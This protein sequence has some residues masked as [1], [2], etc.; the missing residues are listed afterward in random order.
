MR[1]SNCGTSE[2]G[3]EEQTG[4]MPA[5]SGSEASLALRELR[6]LARLVQSGLLAL[7]LT[8]VARKEAFPLEWHAQLGIDLDERPCDAVAYCAGLAA[9]ATAVDA[10][11]DVVAPLE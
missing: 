1:D 8:G 6:R 7:D 10:D 9:R 11:A 2:S 4:A 5:K 3:N